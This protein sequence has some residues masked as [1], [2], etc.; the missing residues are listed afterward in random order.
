[1][2]IWTVVAL[3]Y[4][5]I[6]RH[7]YVLVTIAFLA[8]ASYYDVKEREIDVRLFLAM[9]P[10]CVMTYV[11]LYLAN[12]FPEVDVVTNSIVTAVVA[13]V[14]YVLARQGV[15]GYGDTLLILVV[16]ALNPYLVELWGIYLTPLMLS[17]VFGSAYP[18]FLMVSNLIHNL[19]RRDAFEKAVEGFSR[20]ETLFYLLFG[21]VFSAEEF[22]KTKFYFPLT[23]D[24]KKR[25]IAK[26]GVEPLE[27]SE[28]GIEGGYVIASFGLPLAVALLVGYAITATLIFINYLV[29]IHKCIPFSILPLLLHNLI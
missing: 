8:V 1:V 2:D 28:H 3:L 17:L 4:G 9:I 6:Y 15:M 25:K 7:P 20:N 13:S 23:A 12:M 19:R 26:V 27:G 29:E 24:G 5:F 18:L 16:G 10:P 14:S 22:K 21:K 11:T